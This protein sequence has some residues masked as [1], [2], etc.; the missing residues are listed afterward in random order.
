VLSVGIIALSLKEGDE[1]VE[2]RT[3]SGEDSVFLTS[4]HG[5]GILF[6]E[7]DVRP[8]GRTAAGVFGMRF[9]DDDELVSMTVIPKELMDR[10]QSGDEVEDRLV[11]VTEHGYG[12]RTEIGE[13]SVQGRGG[14][15]VITIK[16]SDRNGKVVGARL[17]HDDDELMLIT[18]LGQIIRMRVDGISI[19]GRNTQGVRLMTMDDEELVVSTARLIPEDED[20]EFEGEEGLEGEEASDSEDASGEVA[21]E[22]E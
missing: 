7:Q 4:F 11:A 19:I 15:G 14:L 20:E 12:K 18:N 6:S 17:V 3:T 5:Q 22:E 10:V 16:T 1:L 2:V 8:M 9:R 13:F 21:G